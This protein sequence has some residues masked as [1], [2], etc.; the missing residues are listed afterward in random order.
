MRQI[1]SKNTK[2]EILVRSLAHRLGYRFRLH[3]GD[4][5]GK[6]D[7][8][9]P[10]SH[11][12][13]FVHGCFWHQ[14]RNCIDGRLPKSRKE[15]WLPKLNRNCIRDKRNRTKLRQLGWHALVVWECQTAD[16]VKLTKVLN[17][18]LKRQR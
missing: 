18:F 10:R 16:A 15:Y 5:P 13:I 6:P 4:L 7:L 11:Q 2:P 14:H 12:V 17:K 1:R 3:R 8:V 9:F